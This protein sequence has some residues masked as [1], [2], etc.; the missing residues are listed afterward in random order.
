VW[1]HWNK[2]ADG[3][4]KCKYCEQTYTPD[5]GRGRLLRH[6]EGHRGESDEINQY[7]GETDVEFSHSVHILASQSEIRN[8]PSKGVAK[9]LPMRR[10]RVSTAMRPVSAYVTCPGLPPQPVLAFFVENL[11]PLRVIE[12]SSF[13]NMLNMSGF[14]RYHIRDAILSHAKRVRAHMLRR[15]PLPV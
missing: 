2:R 10:R 3:R 1:S 4:V 8:Q 7:F 11:V 13:T 15:S 9:T 5:A 14:T 12:S 6:L